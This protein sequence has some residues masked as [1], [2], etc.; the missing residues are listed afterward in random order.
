[1]VIA[2]NDY[3][4]NAGSGTYQLTVNGL[5]DGLKLCLPIIFGTNA[6][7]GGIGGVSNA[8]FILYTQE[9][10]TFCDQIAGHFIH[11]VSP[12]LVDLKKY[13]AAM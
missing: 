13:C 9:Y 1:V 10:A 4:N 6:N 12:R 3:Y 8:T 2:N 11:H 5:T 7:L